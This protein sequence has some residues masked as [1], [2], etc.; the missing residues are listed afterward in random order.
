LEASKGDFWRFLNIFSTIF[1][2]VFNAHFFIFFFS[3]HIF[4]SF[5]SQ[6]KK[7]HLIFA[8][9]HCYDAE[10]NCLKKNPKKMHIFVHFGFF[11]SI[12]FGFLREKLEKVQKSDFPRKRSHFRKKD[13]GFV[14]IKKNSI[15]PKLFWGS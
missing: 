7:P 5:F 1:A 10:I 11:L 3:L 6:S 14:T 15:F 12:T 8:N 13:L 4:C 9:P 2:L